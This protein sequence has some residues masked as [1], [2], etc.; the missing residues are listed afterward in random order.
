MG[1]TLRTQAHRSPNMADETATVNM[2]KLYFCGGF[3]CCY[4][5]LYC[6]CPEMLGCAGESEMCCIVEKFCC[7]IGTAPLLCT[8]PEPKPN[9]AATCCQLGCVSC[10]C[11][12]S[13]LRRSLAPTRC[14]TPAV[15]FL[16][17]LLCQH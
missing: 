14:R 4:N 10:S 7:R 13:R 1:G 5:G 8:P 6:D 11:A 16:A 2:E 17:A 3:C 15:Y 9:K 12:S